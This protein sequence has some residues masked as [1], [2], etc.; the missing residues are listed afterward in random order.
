MAHV[1]ENEILLPEMGRMLQEGKSVR[2]TP[3]G[4]SMRPWIEGGRDAVVLRRVDADIRVGQVLLCK[5][6]DR[7]VLHRLRAI[8]QDGTLVLQGDGNIVGQ[9]RCA[10]A[11]VLGRVTAVYAASGRRKWLPATTLWIRLPRLVRKYGLKIYRKL[12]V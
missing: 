3:T 10:K 12:F 1:V 9:E 4:V 2:F 6:G 5:V 7:F 11:D 8:E